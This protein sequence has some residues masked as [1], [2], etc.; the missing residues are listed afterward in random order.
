MRDDDSSRRSDRDLALR[1][2]RA[3]DAG[4]MND[5]IISHNVEGS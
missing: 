1:A 3:R 4:G 2:C 5:D